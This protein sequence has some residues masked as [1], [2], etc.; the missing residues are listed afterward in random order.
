M[1]AA[2]LINLA[3]STSARAAITLLSPSRFCCA[4]LLKLAL[5]SGEKMMSLMRMPSIATPH[6]SATSPTI[7]AI[8]NAMASRS[9]TTDCTARAPT[10][11]R[12]VVC[13][14][15]VRACRRSV[16]PKAER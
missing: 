11:C 14:R 4:A 7:S 9:V 3:E 16:I 1:S 13:A 2:C 10:T 15:S 6:L 8:S 5:T 12:R